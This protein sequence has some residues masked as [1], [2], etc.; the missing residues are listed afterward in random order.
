MDFHFI[1]FP[2]QFFS[3]SFCSFHSIF[4]NLAHSL[5]SDFFRYF[6]IEIQNFW[7][8]ADKLGRSIMWHLGYF[9][10]N[11]QHPFCFRILM[12]GPYCCQNHSLS[13]LLYCLNLEK[14]RVFFA[15]NK[16]KLLYSRHLLYYSALS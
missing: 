6:F 11:Y 15:I 7:G 13:Y 3:I 4:H 10:P 5:L 12:E 16:I 2:I 14:V 8:W 9:R 1:S